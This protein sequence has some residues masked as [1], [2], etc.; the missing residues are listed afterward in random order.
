MAGKGCCGR[1]MRRASA[2]T[3]LRRRPLAPRSP[4]PAHSAPEALPSLSLIPK[5]ERDHGTP[6]HDEAQ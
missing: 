5:K 3:G 4:A 2:G 1:S 6:D